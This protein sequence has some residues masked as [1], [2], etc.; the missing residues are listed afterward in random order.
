MSTLALVSPETDVDLPQVILDPANKKVRAQK[1]RIDSSITD[2]TLERTVDGAS[3]LTL[4]VHDPSRILLRSGI[5]DEAIDV[6]LD[7]LWFRLCQMSKASDDLTL[8]FEDREVAYLRQHKGP[9]KANRASI[10]RAEFA[11]SLVREVKQEH[12][13]FV[14][15]E[16]TVVQQIANQKQARSSSS[17][18]SQK[19]KGLSPTADLTVK[20][21]QADAGQRRLG[22]QVLDV[23]DSLNA[24]AK[25]QLALMEACIVESTIHNLAGGDRDSRGVLQVRDS[26][27]HPMGLDNRDPSACAHAFLQRGFTGRGGAISLARSH[28][29][30]TAGQ[31]AQ[32]VQ[33]SAFPKAYDGAQIEAQAW[34]DAYSGSSASDSRQVTK[35]LPYQFRRGG[36]NGKNET[37]W[38]CLTRLAQEVNWR[39]FVNQGTVYFIS[40][41]DLLQAKPSLIVDEDS[42]AVLGIDF[43]LDSGKPISEVTLTARAS[44]WQ[45]DPG[46]VVQLRNCGPANGRWLVSDVTR[47]LFDAGATVTLKA[48]SRPFLEPAPSTSITT[49]KAGAAA[50]GAAQGSMADQAYQAAVAMT[51][52][53]YPY[54]WGGG[55]SRAGTPSG[56]PPPGFDCSGS[57]CAIL[58]A[59]GMGFREGGPV[60]TSGVIASSWGVAGEGQAITVWANA[61]HVFM[62]FHTAQGDRHFG[63]GNWGKGW[64]GAGFN[65]NLHPTAGFHP[66]HWPGT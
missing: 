48:P 35:K 55:H 47:G 6:E 8:T 37:S 51:K 57:T 15:P 29:G 60:D 43:D 18:S 42:Q 4:V 28:S 61:V 58:A 19:Q 32:A 1:E 5:F 11:L 46:E 3:T 39:C 26:T 50:S 17:R 40:D 10:T 59:G 66:R 49:T 62:V 7:G 27:A 16:L 41:L 38:D 53:R 64:G 22:Q 30:W 12:I 63:T 24:P 34:L 23:A 9:K 52:K 54:V 31:I 45:V 33:G 44:R 25:A 13:P 2:G 14:C 21:R 36:Q 56:G 65:P 20:G